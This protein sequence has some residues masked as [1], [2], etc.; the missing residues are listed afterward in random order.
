MTI[1]NRDSVPMYKLRDDSKRIAQIQK[2]TIET[3]TFGI[4]PTHGLFGS[5]EWWANIS[6]GRLQRHTLSGVITR[7]YF[8]SMGDW[9]MFEM[10]HGSGECTSWTREVNAKEQDAFYKIGVPIEVD[11]V[12]Q[13]HRPGSFDH[14]AEF[15]CVLEIRTSKPAYT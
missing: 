6:S 13:R 3:E 4:E 1:N 2:A 10:K 9:P 7:I 5:E 15:K 8:G 14:G 11:Y 12:V